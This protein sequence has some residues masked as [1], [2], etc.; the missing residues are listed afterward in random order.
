MHQNVSTKGFI[1]HAW[2]LHFSDFFLEKRGTLKQGAITYSAQEFILWAQ[3]KTCSGDP[4]V[5]HGTNQAE[6]WGGCR[7]LAV[8]SQ[9]NKSYIVEQPKTAEMKQ[10]YKLKASCILNSILV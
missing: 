6:S 7:S 10:K 8:C 2:Y 9:T 4:R 1:G 3:V 5:H